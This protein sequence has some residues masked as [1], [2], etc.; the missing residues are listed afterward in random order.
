MTLQLLNQPNLLG[1]HHPRQQR[2][3]SPKHRR[4]QLS[5]RPQKTQPP[6]HQR[7]TIRTTHKRLQLSS[8]VRATS[9]RNPRP[10]SK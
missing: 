4:K 3:P 9:I 10:S 8:Q 6:I 5:K 7:M 2:N 1:M